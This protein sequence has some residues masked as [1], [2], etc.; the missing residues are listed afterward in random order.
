MSWQKCVRRFARDRLITWLVFRGEVNAL[1][2][3]VPVLP[4][5]N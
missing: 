5:A 1:F 2:L 4:A 3:T